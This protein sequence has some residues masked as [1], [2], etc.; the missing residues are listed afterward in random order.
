[1]E[2][3]TAVIALLCL[4][5]A[6]FVTWGMNTSLLLETW[7]EME[8]AGSG[9]PVLLQGIFQNCT[10]LSTTTTTCTDMD[11]TL[12]GMVDPSAIFM[13]YYYAC[14]ACSTSNLNI[15]VEVYFFQSR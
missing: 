2:P 10:I 15:A 12:R 3:C 9:E 6:G 7:Y 13:N 5:I 14:K 8:P 4:S 11:D 1:M